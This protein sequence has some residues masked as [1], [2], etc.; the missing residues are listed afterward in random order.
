ML[1]G[2][3]FPAQPPQLQSY[4]ETK[5]SS[6]SR[7][8]ALEEVRPMHMDQNIFEKKTGFRGE[9]EFNPNFVKLV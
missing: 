5:N 6:T 7:V 4:R 3:S 9:M 2:S 1:Q 8:L